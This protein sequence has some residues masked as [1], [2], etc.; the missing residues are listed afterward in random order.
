MAWRL[1]FLPVTFLLLGAQD[2]PEESQDPGVVEAFPDDLSTLIADDPGGSLSIGRGVLD[3]FKAFDP[4]IPITVCFFRGKDSVNRRIVEVATQWNSV[5]PH[6]RLDF[7]PNGTIRQCNSATQADIRVSTGIGTDW[8][9]IGKDSHQLSDSTRASMSLGNFANRPPRDPAEF[10]RRV[11]HEFGHALGFRH[12]HQ[13]AN[14]NCDMI[15]PMVIKYFVVW[16]EEEIKEQMEM[17]PYLA[18]RTDTPGFDRESIMTYSLPAYL[19]EAGESSRCFAPQNSKISKIDRI[20]ADEAY[21]PRSTEQRIAIAREVEALAQAKGFTDKQMAYLRKETRFSLITSFELKQQQNNLM[22]WSANPL[23]RG[24]QDS[25]LDDFTKNLDNW[26]SG[27]SISAP[28]ISKPM[29][30]TQFQ[31]IMTTINTGGLSQK[32]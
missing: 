13:G 6:I 14:S 20:V 21:T 12:E 24:A 25:T 16:S 8:S 31:S 15:W 27:R 18:G 32:N 1:A 28:S 2:A 19:F 4:D 11:L 29:P 17:L 3:S 30:S 26:R 5:S 23:L 7:G 22:Q 9:L 10:E